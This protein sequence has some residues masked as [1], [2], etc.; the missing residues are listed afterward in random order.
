MRLFVAAL[1]PPLAD[2]L[3]GLRSTWG[4]RAPF[5]LSHHQSRT[6]NFLPLLAMPPLSVGDF[7]TL[8]AYVD[9]PEGTDSSLRT[10]NDSIQAVKK[11]YN[12]IVAQW[13]G[14]SYGFD[15]VRVMRLS[16]SFDDSF[17]S[18]ELHRGDCDFTVF[19]A[20]LSS[21]IPIS[22]DLPNITV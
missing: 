11:Y 17:V 2:A 13:D 8:P 7:P 5:N 9:C 1:V 16:L 21:A 20:S 3:H 18:V 12:G 4:P 15:A 6:L 22:T 19:S 10:M 14:R